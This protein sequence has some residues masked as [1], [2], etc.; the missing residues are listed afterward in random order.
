MIRLTSLL[1]HCLQALDQFCLILTTVYVLFPG[2]SFHF[3]A[4]ILYLFI[5]IYYFIYYT[6]IVIVPFLMSCDSMRITYQH[7][8]LGTFYLLIFVTFFV[9]C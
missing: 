4:M 2:Y 8:I 1:L 5:N 3:I 6:L 7:C 9:T